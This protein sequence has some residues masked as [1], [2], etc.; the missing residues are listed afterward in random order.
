MYTQA[1]ALTRFH[2]ESKL[3]SMTWIVTFV[4]VVLV[5]VDIGWGFD[6]VFLSFCACVFKIS[7]F[8][9]D[10]FRL[11]QIGLWHRVLITYNV[12]KRLEKPK[13]IT[14]RA[15]GNGSLRKRWHTSQGYGNTIHQNIPIH[16]CYQFC[17]IQL[18][19]TITAR[20]N[21]RIH[22]EQKRCQCKRR[23]WNIAKIATACRYNWSNQCN[24]Y[25]YCGMQSI[26]GNTNGSTYIEYSHVLSESKWSHLWNA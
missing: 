24:A 18:I 3:E 14:W 16:W 12:Y 10:N 20:E 22:S 4:A 23:L 13:C 2:K 7:I 19:Q 9:V 26:F 8:I 6:D 5:D 17:L 1:G 11:R 21:H 15:T 25:R